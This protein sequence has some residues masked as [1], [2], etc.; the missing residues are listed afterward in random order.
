[1]TK[2]VLLIAG[3]LLAAGSVAAISSPYFR[4]G[5][6]RLGQLLAQFGDEDSGAPPRR[7]GKRHREMDTDDEAQTG[8]E[9]FARSRRARLANRD[10]ADDA[11][12]MPARA[13]ERIGRRS[14]DRAR[15]RQAGEDEAGK[16]GAREGRFTPERLSG[17]E[18]RQF[19]RL[20]R[21]GDGFIDAEELERWAA[22]RS[23]RATQRFLKRFDADG[24]GKV[25]RD[26]FRQFAKA[27][28]ANRGAAGDDEMT[29]AE[30]APTKPGRGIVK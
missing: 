1:M 17:R 15:D 19:S 24:D 10:L 18:E 27:R 9:D 5:Q 4:G 14:A 26:E 11:D 8:K 23:V 2:K 13:R 21:N 6:L 12:D 28:P 25:S 3:V 20:D 29:E 22:E 30:L 7:S 16:V